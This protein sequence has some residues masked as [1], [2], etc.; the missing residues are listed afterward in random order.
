MSELSHK[1]GLAPSAGRGDPVL[2]SIYR[3][4]GPLPQAHLGFPSLR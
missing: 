3:A 2:S 4:S 1:V